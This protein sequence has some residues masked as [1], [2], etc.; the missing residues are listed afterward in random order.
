MSILEDTI[1]G[2]F[3]ENFLDKKERKIKN[4]FKPFRYNEFI[5]EEEYLELF[6]KQKGKCAICGI[7]QN[8]L[9]RRFDIDHIHGTSIV[10]GLLC[11]NCNMGIGQLRDSP[12][13]LRAA[14]DYIE[15]NSRTLEEE[16]K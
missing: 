10:R 13:L 3:N 4:R 5:S 1:I 9:N 15:K 2:E 12:R 14:A 7:P 8:R 11:G 16:F 6:I